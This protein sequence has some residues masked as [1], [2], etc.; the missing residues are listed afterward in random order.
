MKN[1]FLTMLCSSLL[2][3][4]SI[5]YAKPKVLVDCL[6]GYDMTSQL[7]TTYSGFD[8]F[9]L[10]QSKLPIQNLI[11]A[12]PLDLTDTV[13]FMISDNAPELYVSTVQIPNSFF[14]HSYLLAPDSSRYF[15]FKGFMSVE[16]PMTGT[17]KLVSSNYSSAK[18]GIGPK[19]FDGFN[20]AEYDAV[21]RL[22]SNTMVMFEGSLNDYSAYDLSRI[23]QVV[24]SGTGFVNLYNYRYN[25]AAKPVI[26]IYNL[27][28]PADLE[29][30]SG[31]FLCF[32]LPKAQSVKDNSNNKFT[33]NIKPD[34]K[35][36]FTE[37]LYES[38]YAEAPDFVSYQVAGN[39]VSIK[40]ISPYPVLSPLVIKALPDRQ[41]YLGTGSDLAAYSSI[42]ITPQIYSEQSL[43]TILNSMMHNRM[44]DQKMRVSDTKAFFADYHWIDK[45]L[46]DLANSKDF[47]CLYL[48]TDQAYNS[49]FPLRLN[50]PVKS[51]NR[52]MWMEEK[53]IS[54]FRPKTYQEFP[55]AAPELSANGVEYYE[56]G[57]FDK[58]Y[59]HTPMDF[60]GL[61]I[62]NSRH[63]VNPG[64]DYEPM[65]VFYNLDEY[66]YITENLYSVTNYY[67]PHICT[68]PDW[69]RLI[70]GNEN[71]I[72]QG[73]DDSYNGGDTLCCLAVRKLD[74][75]D[76]I[77]GGS[78]AL[79][80]TTYDINNSELGNRML[81]YAVRYSD[82]IVPSVS[83]PTIQTAIN[84]AD[85]GSIIMV[86][87]GIYRENLDF[88]GKAVQVI[89]KSGPDSTFIIPPVA[90]DSSRH[91]VIFNKGE[92]KTTRLSGFTIKN[93]RNSAIWLNNSSPVIDNCK[94][95]S[96]QMN[97]WYIN[98]GAIHADS[99]QAEIRNCKISNINDAYLGGALYFNQW[100]GQLIVTEI[101][102]NSTFSG[103]GVD[104]GSAIYLSNSKGL[105]SGCKIYHNTTD[106]PYSGTV[107]LSSA[108]TLITG[109][110]IYENDSPA[111]SVGGLDSCAINNNLIA[112]NHKV[113]NP[114]QIY[115][116]YC[117]NS[118]DTNR[119]YNFRYNFWSDSLTTEMNQTGWP[120]NISRIY[121]KN[122]N[123]QFATV[124]Y[125][126]WQLTQDIDPQ[127][128]LL[129]DEAILYANYP[130]P[131]NNLT[132]I[133]YSLPSGYNGKVMLTV[134]N[135]CGEE[136]KVLQNSVQA[137]GRYQ[138]VFN[139]SNLAGGLY[140]YKLKT[141]NNIICRKML[142]LK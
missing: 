2:C 112:N 87:P 70:M 73:P 42:S 16:N 114:N 32:D 120:G 23:K 71:S 138:C 69:Q 85:S 101:C 26:R 132:V 66:H 134:Y 57:L 74:K 108:A 135:S 110:Q 106:Y 115:E 129:P 15:A 64:S 118:F 48:L 104:Y 122:D 61:K 25:I 44:I 20:L 51:L 59:D 119:R 17:W 105:I 34:A 126:G 81:N 52:Q 113:H 55:P 6:H 75:G 40:N 125:S 109:N 141:T 127:Q 8:F 18:I 37:I 80:V 9:K 21:V 50:Q 28:S 98:G 68:S 100:Y 121:D 84:L 91:A 97:S 14:F 5:I 12:G 111:F 33:W 60:L 82:L 131:F 107:H 90:P 94:I 36:P 29:I 93:S 62:D 27:N 95:D 3:C 116:I 139:G 137:A 130:N 39:S 140:F 83:Y 72:L 79:L 31:G 86:K 67:P 30:K 49:I 43:R 13:T 53:N 11:F 142:F 88:L 47:L 58:D 46:A 133:N 24:S 41:F 78:D 1:I 123:P 56:Y 99:S 54:Q 89:G 35:A 128:N 19:L 136:V 10:D 4:C 76:I 96:C 92:K 124:D 65:P 38:A 117:Y 77:V 102:E 7:S 63:I 103:Y 45:I 22:W